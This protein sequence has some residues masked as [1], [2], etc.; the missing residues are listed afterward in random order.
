MKGCLFTFV[1][2]AGVGKNKILDEINKKYPDLLTKSVSATTR[3]K[4]PG[5]LEGVDYFF[6]TEEEFKELI[7]KDEF[8]EYTLH[9]NN[10]YGT[11]LSDIQPLINSGKNIVKIIN[12][13]GIKFLRKSPKYKDFPHVS[14]FINAPSEEESEKRLRERED[15]H[16]T[17]DEIK[18][19]MQ[20][21]MEEMKFYEENKSYFNHHIINESLDKT[22]EEIVNIIKS[23][24]KIFKLET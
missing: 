24:T 9:V 18:K 20:V 7:D 21:G 3:P 15:L 19:R 6:K 23:Y 2:P 17:E 5:E 14:I 12:I 13:H 4:R 11:L 22:V 10:Y 16:I 8:I 1:G